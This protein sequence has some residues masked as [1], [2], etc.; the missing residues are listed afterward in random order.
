[1]F[2]FVCRLTTAAGYV[3]NKKT[4]TISK[5][6]QC[7]I[8]RV[9]TSETEIGSFKIISATIEHVGKYSW[10][11]ISLWNNFEIVSGKFPRAEIKINIPDQ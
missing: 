6:F 11:A 1:V 10:A 7:F 9:T 8:S 5:V 4:E 2:Y 3:W